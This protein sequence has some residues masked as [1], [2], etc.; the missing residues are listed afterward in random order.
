MQIGI[1]LDASK[2]ELVVLGKQYAEIE[3]IQ[4]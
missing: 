4:Q 1:K 3:K 2:I